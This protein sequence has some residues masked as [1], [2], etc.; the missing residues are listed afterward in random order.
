MAVA[1][2]FEDET[3]AMPKPRQ[4]MLEEPMSSIVLAALE[5]LLGKRVFEQSQVGATSAAKQSASLRFAMPAEDFVKRVL[6]SKPSRRLEDHPDRRVLEDDYI[7][8]L[9]PIAF[10]SN[11]LRSRAE[12]RF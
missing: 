1:T 12:P 8:H 11:Q 7:V 3:I 9:E 6:L 10:T 5:S 2:T 4:W